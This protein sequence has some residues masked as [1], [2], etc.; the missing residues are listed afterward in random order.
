M[1]KDLSYSVKKFV[2]NAL[3]SHK[4]VTR[5]YQFPHEEEIIIGVDRTEGLSSVIIHMSDAYRYSLHNY[6]MRPEELKENSFILIARPEA[7]FDDE[8]IS[9][10]REDSIG[11]GQIGKLL[12]ALNREYVW[13]YELP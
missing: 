11:V 4:K 7:G 1:G 8:V 13:T 12:G 10:A 5:V 3:T 9:V 6:D 2:T